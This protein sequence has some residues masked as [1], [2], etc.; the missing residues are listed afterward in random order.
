LTPVLVPY[1]PLKTA[2]IAAIVNGAY[3]IV[4]EKNRLFSINFE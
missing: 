2:C 4:V 3:V 1:I